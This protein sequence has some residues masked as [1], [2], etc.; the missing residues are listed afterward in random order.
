MVLIIHRGPGSCAGNVG[1]YVYIKVSPHLDC[2][3]VGAVDTSIG[4]FAVGSTVVILT[5]LFPYPDGNSRLN[6]KRLYL[7]SDVGVQ[8]GSRSIRVRLNQSY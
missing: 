8:W 5:V 7:F 3:S 4:D 6:F 2:H 1:A